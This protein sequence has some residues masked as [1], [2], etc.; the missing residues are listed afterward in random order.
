MYSENERTNRTFGSSSRQ[1]LHAD[2]H[3]ELDHARVGPNGAQLEANAT[4]KSANPSFLNNLKIPILLVRL[5]TDFFRR[6]KKSEI[7][8]TLASKKAGILKANKLI[9]VSKDR[10]K[11]YAN[12]EELKP[13]QS[14]ATLE[15]LQFKMS[16]EDV[17]IQTGTDQPVKLEPLLQNPTVKEPEPHLPLQNANILSRAIDFT[18]KNRFK[19]MKNFVIPTPHP[20]AV[21]LPATTKPPALTEQNLAHIRSPEPII[22]AAA[23]LLAEP[24]D[25]HKPSQQQAV[26]LT[27]KASVRLN[28]DTP[29]P[30]PVP[31]PVPISIPIPVP[32]INN[33]N[34][35]S[36]EEDVHDNCVICCA[37][38]ADVVCMP[39]GHGGIC[40]ICAGKLCRKSKKCFL[41]KEDVKLILWIDPDKPI[42][43]MVV[44][45][46]HID[47]DDIDQ[48]QQQQV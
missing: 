47:V 46:A 19:T 13:A 35:K 48:P 20:T 26:Q 28:T 1:F 44:V 36:V 41:C 43:D 7:K 11:K 3:N 17:K 27:D 15:E 23:H 24:P 16:V 6:A 8:K 5:S 29:D 45:L 38:K 9:P 39:C 42:C 33:N 2:D 10:D 30:I 34:E 22:P 4:V 18:S 32:I 12:F 21:L 14:G 37:R 31:I 40:Q 25:T